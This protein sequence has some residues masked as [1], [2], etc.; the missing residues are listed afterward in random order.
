[1]ASSAGYLQFILE[2]LDGLEGIASRKMMGEYLLYFQG[3]VFGGIYDDRF[4]VKVTQA[5]HALMPSCPQELPYAGA[6]L[7][8]LIQELDDRAFLKRLVVETC[9]ELPAPKPK[10]K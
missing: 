8:F 7:M 3:K 2:R 6:K 1:M 5:G 4:L 10:K 9:R